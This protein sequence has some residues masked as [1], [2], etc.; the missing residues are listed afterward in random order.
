MKIRDCVELPEELNDK[1][2]FGMGY[3]YMVV[4][5]GKYVACASDYG[6]CLLE[7]LSLP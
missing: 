3:P 1:D 4:M 6:I 7:L 5:Y 2:L